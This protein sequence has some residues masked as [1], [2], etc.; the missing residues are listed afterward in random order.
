MSDLSA[1]FAALSPAIRWAIGR[2]DEADL[3]ALPAPERA[4]V[5]TAGPRRRA[6]FATSR[7]LAH[8]SLHALGHPDAGAPLGVDADGLPVWPGGVV[9]SLSHCPAACV[10]AVASADEAGLRSLGVDV[11]L[12]EPLPAGVGPL[13]LFPGDAGFLALDLAPDAP[14]VVARIVFSAKEAAYKA[15]FPRHR[16]SLDFDAMTIHG[17]VDASGRAGSLTATLQLDVPPSPAGT[18]IPGRFCL[19]DGLIVTAFAE[20]LGV[21]PDVGSVARRGAGRASIR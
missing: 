3:D 16:T 4:R 9:G 7:R 12:A 8:A 19:V 13:V 14:G 10:V 15:I 17:S 6:E 11:E 18:A 5:S 2:P 1:L 21:A 20:V